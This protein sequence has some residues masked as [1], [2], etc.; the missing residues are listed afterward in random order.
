MNN[1]LD[2]FDLPKAKAARDKGLA[3]TKTNNEGW[4]ETALRYCETSPQLRAMKEFSGEDLRVAIS[5]HVGQPRSPHGWGLVAR[6]LMERQVIVPTGG[7]KH[8]RTEKSH[9]RLTRVYRW[10]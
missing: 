8:M 2:M 10:L 7:L 6:Y 5:P 4:L 1:Q 3:R 9:A